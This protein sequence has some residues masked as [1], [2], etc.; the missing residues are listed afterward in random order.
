MGACTLALHM[1]HKRET[2]S[3]PPCMNGNESH[4]NPISRGN[5]HLHALA[6]FAQFGDLADLPTFALALRALR[7]HAGRVDLARPVPDCA[8]LAAHIVLGHHPLILVEE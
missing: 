5:L 1:K 3:H 7:Q 6:L 4:M 2:E 8:L